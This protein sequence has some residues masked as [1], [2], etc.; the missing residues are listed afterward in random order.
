MDTITEL[1]HTRGYIDIHGMDVLITTTII[2]TVMIATGYT[3]YQS[4]LLAIRADWD[5]YRCNPLIMPFAG[6]AM[7]VEGKASSLITMENVQYC[8]KKDAAIALSIAVMPIETMMYATVDILDGIQEG[9]TLSMNVTQWLLNKLREQMDIVMNKLKAITIP[10]R[11]MIVRIRDAISKSNAV[12]TTVLYVGMHMYNLIISGVINL[13]KVLS[14]LILITTVITLA[15]AAVAFA[16]IA[17][18]IGAAAGIPM[19]VSAA[20]TIAVSIVPWIVIY[21][22]LRLAVNV[23]SPGSSVPK[24]PPKPVLKKRKKK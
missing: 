5:V 4:M 2:T 14:N 11:E 7:P 3:N 13:M 21:T 9:I 19:Y 12:L 23:L 20:L 16:L 22:I 18:G 17:T 10:L 8:V 24:P 1:Y 6:V 15:L